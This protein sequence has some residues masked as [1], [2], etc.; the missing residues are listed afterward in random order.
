M[1]RRADYEALFDAAPAGTLKGEATP[2]YLYDL[3]AQN[4]VRRF[5]PKARIIV[6]LRNPVDHA[7]SNWTH[8]WA[9]GLEPERDFVQACALERERR[10]AG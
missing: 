8:L 2:F 1:W 5:L 10:D 3:D 4:R 9:A 7:H 6:M